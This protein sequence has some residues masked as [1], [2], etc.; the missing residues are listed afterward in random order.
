MHGK[1]KDFY[2]IRVNDRWRIIFR[3]EHGDAFDVEF[4]DYH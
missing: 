1:L 4:I 3:F 2:S